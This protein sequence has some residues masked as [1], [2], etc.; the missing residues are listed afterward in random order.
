MRKTLA[1]L[2]LA[3]IAAGCGG[4]SSPTAPVVAA[5]PAPTATP[6]PAPIFTVT[7]TGD[8]VFDIPT[9]VTRIKISGT[10]TRNSSNFI[11]R[12]AS[13][14]VV[15]ELLG[16]GWNQTTFEGTY[17]IRGGGTAEITKST[18]VEW[19]FTEVR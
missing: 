3:L 12:I 18:G 5:T 2:A 8:T 17:L 9:R 19:T 14:L 15:N 16:T 4:S 1:V 13:S 10:Y 11:V 6:T 7:G